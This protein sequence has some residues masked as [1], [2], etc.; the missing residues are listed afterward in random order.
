[1]LVIG[2]KVPWVEIETCTQTFS[3]RYSTCNLSL[4]EKNRMQG[5]A[6][7]RWLCVMH[8]ACPYTQFE[9][10]RDRQICFHTYSISFSHNFFSWL[11]NAPIY[12][13]MF[14]ER[15]DAW[16][17]SLIPS[18]S[19]FFVSLLILLFVCVAEMRS[20]QTTSV[21]FCY[22]EYAHGPSLPLI[23]RRKKNDRTHCIVATQ[24]ERRTTNFT[25][26]FQ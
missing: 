13:R 14:V 5:H 18:S 4:G 10:D 3:F 21:N 9:N 12:V 19:L 1:M 22:P 7:F 24:S 20:L 6:L 15:I 25:L 11:F 26:T 16:F 23:I 2:K 17:F 8:A